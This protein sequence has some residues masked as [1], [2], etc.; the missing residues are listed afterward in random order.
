MGSRNAADEAADARRTGVAAWDGWSGRVAGRGWPPVGV[1]V[2][3][4][5]GFGGGWPDREVSGA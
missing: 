4:A 3:A 5:L 1:D 2:T